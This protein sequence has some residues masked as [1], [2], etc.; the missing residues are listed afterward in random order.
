MTLNEPD[1]SV[2]ATLVI[3][4]PC[5][6][7][8]GDLLIHHNKDKHRFVSENLDTDS[9]D[10]VAFY[11][12]CPHEIEKVKKGTRVVLTYNLVLEGGGV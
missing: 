10:C 8:G 1:S 2:V 5:P 9:I 11:A 3:A 4:L 6:H 7:I 12:D